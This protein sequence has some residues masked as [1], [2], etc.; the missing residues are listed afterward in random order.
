MLKIT[1]TAK[2]C[3][4]EKCFERSYRQGGKGGG[5]VELLTLM[6]PKSQKTEY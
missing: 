4:R 6:V 5:G 1:I 3:F 2:L